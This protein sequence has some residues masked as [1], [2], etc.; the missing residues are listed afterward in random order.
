MCNNADLNTFLSKLDERYEAKVK[1]QGMLM[2]KKVR[3]IGSMSS[4]TPPPEAAGWTID[5]EWKKSMYNT[6]THL[7]CKIV[8]CIK[9]VASGAHE[10][11]KITRTC[12][13]YTTVL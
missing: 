5:K 9:L 10:G 11:R 6:G 1:K 4:S 3:K 8:Y 13:C 7:A 12:T 2:A